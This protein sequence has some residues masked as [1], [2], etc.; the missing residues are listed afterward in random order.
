MSSNRH[1]ITAT[2]LLV[3]MAFTPAIAFPAGNNTG[4]MT[5]ADCDLLQNSKPADDSAAGQAAAVR[6]GQAL[7]QACKRTVA[8]ANANT[9]KAEHDRERAIQE[10]D[11]RPPKNITEEEWRSALKKGGSRPLKEYKY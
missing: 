9:A 6:K 5:A 11:A 2:A 3:A 8:T 1:D 4:T 7:R 10:R